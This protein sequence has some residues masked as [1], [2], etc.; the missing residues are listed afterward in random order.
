MTRLEGLKARVLTAV[1]SEIE[2][3]VN[4]VNVRAE[5]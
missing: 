2:G 3:D 1:D 4:G 5:L